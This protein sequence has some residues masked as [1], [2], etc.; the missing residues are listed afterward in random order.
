MPSRL[1]LDRE[2]RG[3]TNGVLP[4]Y[5]ERG[6]IAK[7]AIS[8][9][10]A[11]IALI[12]MT[13]T[14]HYGIGSSCQLEIENCIRIGPSVAETLD[15]SGLVSAVRGALRQPLEFPPLASCTVP[16]DKVVVALQKGLPMLREIVEGLREALQDAGVEQGSVRFVFESDPSA[17]G[18]SLDDWGRSLDIDACV[19]LPDDH[20]HCSL[21]SVMQ[22][23]E[24]L[25]MNR[26]LGEAD[27]VLPVGLAAC[28]DGLPAGSRFAGLYPEFADQETLNRF[29]GVS[30]EKVSRVSQ[31]CRDEV[32]EAGWLLGVNLA[33]R[34]VP[35]PGGTVAGV[36]AGESETVTRA[37]SEQFQQL[38]KQSMPQQGDLVIASVG[39]PAEEQS[40]EN[41]CRALAAAETALQP[42]GV[43]VI[44]T[45]LSES[46]GPALRTLAGG[47]DFDQLQLSLGR[48]KA[49][50]GAVALRLCRALER[51]T[52]YLS[53]QLD[54]DV[55]ESLGLAPIQSEEELRRLT[56]TFQR[57]VVLEDAHR[58]ICEG[59]ES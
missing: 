50:D 59:G 57:I 4:H 6:Q 19:H 56:D 27:F 55:V 11:Q 21:V 25:R 47:C 26:E 54:A 30:Q 10:S 36:L 51:G 42:G 46:P 14:L 41:V 58:L 17:E 48:V 2:T 44:C 23:G 31:K 33:V 53:S 8:H 40:W 9:P 12:V 43:I 7:F 3:C 45:Q 15:P 34:I 38:W 39:G 5:R 35:G 20:E 49:P 24:P 1:V 13:T 22:S 29:R 28:D 32:D 16:G 52:V 18:D 37:A